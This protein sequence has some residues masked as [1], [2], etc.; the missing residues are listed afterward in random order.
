MKLYGLKNCDS[1][2]TALKE[3]KKAGIHVEF[4]DIKTNPVS[5]GMLQGWLDQHGDATI[6]NRRS[7][8][9]RNL[10]D[11]NR[12]TPAALLLQVHPT[13]IKR[14]IIVVDERSYVGWTEDV[15]YALGIA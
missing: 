6:L 8:T 5:P 15:K 12:Q 1:C 2:K 7:T 3:I 10:D 13:L 14:P 9:W 11:G 4:I